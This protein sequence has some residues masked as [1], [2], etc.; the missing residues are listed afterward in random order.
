MLLFN[1]K[2]TF[3][4]LFITFLRS[5]PRRQ[6]FAFC[7]FLGPFIKR[8]R[9]KDAE[10]AKLQLK[11]IFPEKLNNEINSIVSANFSHLS[12]AFYEGLNL[13]QLTKLKP[14]FLEATSAAEQP[15]EYVKFEG[16]ITIFNKY[17]NSDA[18]CVI[19]SGHIGCFELIAACAAKF[20]QNHTQRRLFAIGRNPNHDILD[21]LLKD[22]RFNYGVETIW[23]ND[24][25]AITKLLKTIKEKNW[26]AVLIDQDTELENF[27][28]DFF[29]IP[30]AYP[31]TLLRY[32][33]KHS[34]PLLSAFIVRE[35]D[36]THTIHVTPIDY[37]TESK[38]EN[39]M[40]GSILSAYSAKLEK[41]IRKH[42]DQ[43]PWWHRRWRRQIEDKKKKSSER[44]IAWLTKKLQKKSLKQI[45]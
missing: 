2:L 38:D 24:P 18:P 25:K 15:F 43:W 39:S 34:I 5:L 23:R 21:S 13:E 4:K 1:I 22:I 7:D 27:W 10:V 17:L 31:V 12:K 28:V 37:N 42:P 41:L 40:I 45:F 33:V 6:F 3:A 36:L 26:L 8:R 32:A 9:S 29:G 20:K 44:Y 16:D 19:L 30:A 35:S 11:L 14:Q